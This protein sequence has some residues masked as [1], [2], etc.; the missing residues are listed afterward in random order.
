MK[1]VRSKY[2]RQPEEVKA[3]RNLLVLGRSAL[4]LFLAVLD[5]TGERNESRCLHKGK[6]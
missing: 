5:F 2:D 3:V 4:Y 1:W 6:N